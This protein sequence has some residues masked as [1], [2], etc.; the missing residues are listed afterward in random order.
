MSTSKEALT[1]YRNL[2]RYGSRIATYNFREYALRRTRDA[3][4]A[5]KDLTDQRKIQELFQKGYKELDVLKRQSTISQMYQGEKVIVEHDRPKN[6]IV[7]S[8]DSLSVKPPKTENWEPSRP[9]QSDRP[10]KSTYGIKK[11]CTYIY[12]SN[13]KQYLQRR[14]FL[15]VEVRVSNIHDLLASAVCD[16][17]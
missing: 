8:H 6:R 9:L 4:Q 13:K 7:S 3:F 14:G 16:L 2:L 11:A 1:L 12:T 10:V 17:I 15:E 5:S